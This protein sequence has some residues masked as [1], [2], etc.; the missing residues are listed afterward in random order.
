MGLVN[1]G[2]TMKSVFG[3]SVGANLNDMFATTVP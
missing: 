2:G 3:K 1:A